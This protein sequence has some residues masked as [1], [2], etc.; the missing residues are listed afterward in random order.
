MAPLRRTS[1]VPYCRSVTSSL[2]RR[3]T[4]PFHCPRYSFTCRQVGIYSLRVNQFGRG[5]LIGQTLVAARRLLPLP[6]ILPHCCPKRINGL[7]DRC[8]VSRCKNG[9]PIALSCSS[10]NGIDEPQNNCTNQNRNRDGA[11]SAN[12]CK[13]EHSCHFNSECHVN[14]HPSLIACKITFLTDPFSAD[15]TKR[16][17]Q[18][19]GRP[20]CRLNNSI[21]A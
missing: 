8:S 5:Y 2:L 3:I 7:F 16:T 14:L 1:V 10:W 12:H 15:G 9:H 17:P 11:S 6:I 4:A 13:G 21:Q 18:A 19:A 20:I